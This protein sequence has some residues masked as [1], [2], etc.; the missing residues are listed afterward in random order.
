MQLECDDGLA[1]DTYPGALAH[2][3]TNLVT[4]SLTHAFDEGQR[5]SVRIG[6]AVEGEDVVLCHAD[7]GKGIP[8]D[9][10]PHIFDPFFTTARAQGGTGLGLHI[11]FNAVVSG[12]AG[13][14][15]VACPPEGGTVF[16]IRFPRI[17]PDASQP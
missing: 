1:C 16:T 12:L 11:A 6:A 7:D 4:N 15:A 10:L 17:H 2:L 3:V 8:P 14:I 9:A 5:G 13:A